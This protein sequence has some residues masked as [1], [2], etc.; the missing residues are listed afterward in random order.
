[1]QIDIVTNENH[2]AVV[3]R[4]LPSSAVIRKEDTYTDRRY[5]KLM[6]G[7]SDFSDMEVQ[8]CLLIGTEYIINNRRY[9]L[10]SGY[11]IK[12]KVTPAFQVIP[13]LR[14]AKGREINVIKD[15]DGR[16][17]LDR[18][19]VIV[20]VWSE[21]EDETVV[22]LAEDILNIEIEDENSEEEIEDLIPNEE[23]E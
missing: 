1:M 16:G 11:A 22:K 13:E 10:A 8:D 17:I 3:G 19:P 14:K 6:S 4:S 23:E 18:W 5:F 2:R 9:D 7:L 21:N 12:A 20:R 15:E